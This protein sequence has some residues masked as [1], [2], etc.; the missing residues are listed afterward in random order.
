MLSQ[1]CF[2]FSLASEFFSSHVKWYKTMWASEKYA[3]KGKL[4]D[5]EIKSMCS[6]NGEKCANLT[7]SGNI[8]P[9]DINNK[10]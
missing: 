5:H 4:H 9:F 2:E 6:F 8:M 3:F 10:C 1:K 7:I